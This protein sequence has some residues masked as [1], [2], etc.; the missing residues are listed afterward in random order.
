MDE[1][2]HGLARGCGISAARTRAAFLLEAVHL[3]TDDGARRS[4]LSW[5]D[6]E[7]SRPCPACV[8]APVAGIR[9]RTGGDWLLN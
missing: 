9:A 7:C 8:P 4:L 1:A 2:C 5:G 6:S 3:G